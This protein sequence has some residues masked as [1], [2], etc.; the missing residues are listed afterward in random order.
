[1]TKLGIFTKEIH[2]EKIVNFL[3]TTN[4]D[5]IIST[6]REGPYSYHFDVGISYC[7]PHIV[8]VNW[9]GLNR[10]WY[11]YH[12]G[13]LPDYKGP[14]EYA[15]TL[16]QG[17]KMHGVT[18]HEMTMDVDAGPI[19]ETRKFKLASIP[20]HD[21]ELGL[22]AHYNLFQLFKDTIE[23][24]VKKPDTDIPPPLK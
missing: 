13:L 16:Y 5:F 3:R 17:R 19:I 9:M 8:D 11:N 12:P 18:L 21:S 20:V 7:F 15:K 10:R 6:R 1:M 23:L 24:L 2:V 14:M 22:I 4:I